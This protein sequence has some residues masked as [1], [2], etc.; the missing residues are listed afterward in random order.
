MYNL[1][2]KTCVNTCKQDESVKIVSCPKYRKNPSE[3]EFRDM[4][5]ELETADNNARQAHQ[6]VKGIIAQ[7]ISDPSSEPEQENDG[8]D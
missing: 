5:D 3:N 8:E 1:L 4:L 7:I 6:K 2:C